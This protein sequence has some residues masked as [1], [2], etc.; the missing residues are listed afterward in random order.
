MIIITI[1][2]FII[3]ILIN[4]GAYLK[5]NEKKSTF[6]LKLEKENTNYVFLRWLLLI[7]INAVFIFLLPLSNIYFDVQG[8][9]A[10]IDSLATIGFVIT[11]LMCISIYLYMLRFKNVMNITHSLGII[12]LYSIEFALMLMFCLYFVVS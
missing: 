12:L 6:S 9:Q 8:E 7:L 4:T 1:L 3:Y 5:F 11:I 10:L 2:V